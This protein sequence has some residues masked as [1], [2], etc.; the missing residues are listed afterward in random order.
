MTRH[1]LLDNVTHKNLKVLR[2]YAPGHG[3]D[4]NATRVFPAEF[5]QL[6]AEYPLFFARNRETGHFDAIALLGFDEGENLYLGDGEWLA[7]RLPMTIER[8]PFLIGFQETRDAGAPAP[9]PVV[10]VDLDHPSVGTEEG[11]PVFLPHGGEAALLERANA[12]LSAIHG[13]HDDAQVLSQLLVGLELIESVNL[14]VEFNDGSFHALEGLYTINEE[15]LATLNAGALEALHAKGHLA[16]V[17][18]MLA[19]LAQ[20]SVLI[21]RKNARLAN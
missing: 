4:V 20:L 3:Y 2:R 19:S 14:E 6:Q 7:R 13:G 8:Q 12:V 17:F 9:T 16:S 18:M 11:E 21:E 1:V 10:H 15:K 5:A